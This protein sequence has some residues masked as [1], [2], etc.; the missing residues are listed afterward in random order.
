LGVNF[1]R[2]PFGPERRGRGYRQP[3]KAEQP[4]SL[5]AILEE[6]EDAMN[7]LNEPQTNQ[8]GA[9]L[10]DMI[11]RLYHELKPYKEDKRARETREK[12]FK[13]LEENGRI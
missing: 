2:F 6:T 10:L 11:Y 9:M 3:L 4:R 5:E 8:S 7:S 12:L 1:F 13:I